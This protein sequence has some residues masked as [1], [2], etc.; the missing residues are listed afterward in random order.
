MSRMDSQSNEFVLLVRSNCRL[1]GFLL[2]ALG[3][4]D[5]VGANKYFAFHFR[6]PE[7]I[8]QPVEA[9][10]DRHGFE[11]GGHAGDVTGNV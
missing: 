9:G 1:V 3:F 8:N 6:H 4:G 2:R 11:F 5:T 10:R 7:K